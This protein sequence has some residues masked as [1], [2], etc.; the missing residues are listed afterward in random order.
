M[1]RL[2]RAGYVAAVLCACF[3]GQQARAQFQG[4][5]ITINVGFSAG[6]GYDIYARAL[7]RYLGRHLAG[8]PNVI[9]ENM[10]GA[11][12]LKSVEYLDANAP[13]D[14]TAITAFN[15]GLITE[16]LVDPKQVNFDFRN[17]AWLGSIT[18]DER[19]CYAWAATG[20]KS[21]D[22]LRR[23]KQFTLGAPAPGTSSYIS[24]EILKKIFSIP[25]REVMGYPGS[26]EQR[27]A[28]ER[29]ELDGDC[30]SVAS[31]PPDW[32]RQ[33]KIN[34]LLRFSSD[35]I[36]GLP[37]APPF[38][39]SFT[40]KPEIKALLHILI[41]PDDV[42]RPYVVSK[43]IPRDR[44][45]ELR[46]AFAATVKDPDFRSDM[47]KIGLPIVYPLNGSQS[48]TLIQSIYASPAGIVSQARAVL[49]K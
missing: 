43:A 4:K 44:L 29:G 48:E 24:A 9:V 7:S 17:V 35:P 45:A 39:A 11:S 23:V 1:A 30:G 10:P 40:D 18:R 5:T 34:P 38:I 41:A 14:G 19:I 16:S 6:G 33:G 32:L 26:A 36:A 46:D 3:S 15:P 25:V 13:K 20:I 31:I 27:I 28:I 47:G 12:S 2:L 8:R 22:N 21:F 49:A 37:G 42:G